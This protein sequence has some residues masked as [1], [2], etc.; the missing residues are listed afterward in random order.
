MRLHRRQ[1]LGVP[2]EAIAGSNPQA[3]LDTAMYPIKNPL[4]ARPA[5]RSSAATCT[6]SATST[7]TFATCDLTPADATCAPEF[8]IT[9]RN[10]SYPFANPTPEF[11]GVGAAFLVNGAHRRQ[12]RARRVARR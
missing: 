7:A 10:L 12:P 11:T 8:V 9:A 3:I 2:G 4:S 6:G 5:G 1:G